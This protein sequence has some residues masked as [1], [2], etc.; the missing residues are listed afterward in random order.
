MEGDDPQEDSQQQQPDLGYFSILNLNFFATDQDFKRF[1]PFTSVFILYNS[2]R[3]YS[4]LLP[5]YYDTI[6]G[7]LKEKDINYKEVGEKVSTAFLVLENEGKRK[8]YFHMLEV[9]YYLS[10]PFDIEIVNSKYGI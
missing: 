4:E 3:N 9:R 2:E 1:F 7:S 6:N 10:Q 8:N 5:I